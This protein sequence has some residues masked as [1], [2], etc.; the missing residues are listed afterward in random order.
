MLIGVTYSFFFYREFGINI[1][2]FVDLSDFLLTPIL[3]PLSIAIFIVWVFISWL[4]LRFEFYLRNR[5][6]S[7]GRFNKKTLRSKYMDPILF[8]A[9][10]IFLTATFLEILAVKNVEK[11]RAGKIDEYQV[12]YSDLEESASKVSLALLGGSS[13]YLYFF[14]LSHQK[15]LIIPV[16]NVTSLEKIK[17]SDIELEL[18]P[19]EQIAPIEQEKAAPNKD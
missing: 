1:L 18:S 19:I 15:I 8:A 3:E 11:I 2:K 9:G 16:E 13:R 14:N 17:P 6:K 10:A 4:G 12:N 5:F 7:Y